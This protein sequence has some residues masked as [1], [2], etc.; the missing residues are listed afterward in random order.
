MSKNAFEN[1]LAR[2]NTWASLVLSLGIPFVLCVLK[3]ARLNF[4]LNKLEKVCLGA[5]IV[6]LVLYIF[7]FITSVADGRIIWHCYPFLLLFYF[8]Q[9]IELKEFQ[10]LT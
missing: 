2:F 8:N 7:S 1:N 3:M 4:R 10:K 5:M 9:E 6:T